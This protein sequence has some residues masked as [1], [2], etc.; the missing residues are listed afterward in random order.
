MESVLVMK[1]RL[2]GLS[3]MFIS[4]SK[5]VIPLFILHQRILSITNFA[6]LSNT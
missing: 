1:L 6:C 2:A 3:K 5:L 4:M